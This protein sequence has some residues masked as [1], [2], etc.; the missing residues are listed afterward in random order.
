MATHIVIA[1]VRIIIVIAKCDWGRSFCERIWHW[2]SSVVGLGSCQLI[3]I[4][5][6][7]IRL[8]VIIHV[9]VQV[10]HIII[11][12]R[13]ETQSVLIPQQ[14]VP[15]VINAIVINA[16]VINVIVINAIV[17]ITIVISLGEWGD[18]GWRLCTVFRGRCYSSRS[19]PGP[20]RKTPA[21]GG[22]RFTLEFFIL[23]RCSPLTMISLEPTGFLSGD[24]WSAAL[25]RVLLVVVVIV[26]V[27]KL[28]VKLKTIA[29]H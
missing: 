5:V 19:I 14:S 22:A 29:L 7:L 3:N 11:R 15:I 13:A 25:P 17:I 28:N 26:P 1:I 20:G 4:Q 6:S 9:R 18:T 24:L 8:N 16:I 21:K 27:D 2:V 12:S 10:I 23:P